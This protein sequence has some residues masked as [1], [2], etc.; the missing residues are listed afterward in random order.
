MPN[1]EFRFID[2]D[3]DGKICGTYARPQREGQEALPEGNAELVSFNAASL[4]A[5]TAP[6]VD[7]LEDLKKRVEALEAK[8][9]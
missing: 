7:P 8:V 1:M 5:M 4:A 3:K 9:Q 2:R 6:K